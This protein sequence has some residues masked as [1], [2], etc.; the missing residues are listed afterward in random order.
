MIVRFENVVFMF[1]LS[2]EP[3][4]NN[5]LGAVVAACSCLCASGAYE[6]GV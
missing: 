4:F 6:W 2:R 1:F 5:R 3:F